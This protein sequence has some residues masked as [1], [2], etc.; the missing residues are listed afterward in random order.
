MTAF[1]RPQDAINGNHRYFS[2]G[3]KRLS[4]LAVVA[5]AL[6]VRIRNAPSD[7]PLERILAP[8]TGVDYSRF[9]AEVGGF[10]CQGL[11]GHGSTALNISAPPPGK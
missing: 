11:R 8:T 4:E 2:L 6:W 9:G 3:L 10:Y 5:I 7:A 1:P